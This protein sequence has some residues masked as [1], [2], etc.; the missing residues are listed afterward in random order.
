MPKHFCQKDG[1]GDEFKE[2]VI[3]VTPET[4]M[5]EFELDGQMIAVN[6]RVGRE[7][8]LPKCGP[9]RRWGS[10]IGRSPRALL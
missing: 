10:Q 2:L 6:T 5:V 8:V 1:E 3:T 9:C 4:R 7:M